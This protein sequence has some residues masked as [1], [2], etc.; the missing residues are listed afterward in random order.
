MTHFNAVFDANSLGKW[1]Y[2]WARHRYE[3]DAP[4]IKASGELWLLI[5]LMARKL[6]VSKKFISESVGIE[7]VKQGEDKEMVE[8]FIEN[9]EHV[10]EKLQKH[11]EKCGKSMLA[12]ENKGKYKDDAARGV[13]LAEAIF[14]DHISTTK[15]IMQNMALWIFR[16]DANCSVV[17]GTKPDTEQ[18]IDD[19]V[20]DGDRD[21]VQ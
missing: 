3:A 14:R 1:I 13:A 11:L 17:V 6:R 4:E 20:V 8:D 10:M 9:G 15:R 18:P 16:W 19:D 12:S 21:S 7:S 2:G 5:M